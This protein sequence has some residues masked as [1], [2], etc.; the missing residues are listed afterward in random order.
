MYGNSAVQTDYEN[1]H[2]CKT[3]TWVMSE[4]RRTLMEQSTSSGCTE[5]RPLNRC[6][7]VI[8]T[9]YHNDQ[10]Q[11][12][13]HSK[14]SVNFLLASTQHRLRNKNF[15]NDT[16]NSTSGK[17][18]SCQQGNNLWQIFIWKYELKLFLFAPHLAFFGF[19]Q[20]TISFV[21]FAVLLFGLLLLELLTPSCFSF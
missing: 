18:M 10:T 16:T 20:D 6:H 5:L 19:G 15:R 2:L 3:L 9:W 17:S 7:P 14:D 8:K 4:C 1:L 21:P 11:F 13:S 12:P